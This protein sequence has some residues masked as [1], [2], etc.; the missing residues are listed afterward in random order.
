MK[1]FHIYLV[2]NLIIASAVFTPAQQLKNQTSEIRKQETSSASQVTV[3]D[4]QYRIGSGDVLEVRVF[5]RPQLSR[6]AV[7]VDGAGLVTMP[8]IDEGIRAACKTESELAHEIATRYLKYQRNPHVSVFVKEFNSQP[9]AV[10]GAVNHPGRFQLQRRLRLLEL[11]AFAGGPSE[12]AGGRIDIIRTSGA[13]CRT[14]TA[15]P[16]R[17]DL[18]ATDLISVKLAE[19]LSGD[20]RANPY[21]Q[22]GDIISMPEAEQA[23]VV[24]NVLKPSAIN[25]KEPVTVSRAI[26]MAG[27]VMPDTKL[28]RIR[29]VRRSS[30]S[31]TNAEIF[32]DLRAIDKLEAEDVALQSGDIV[33]VQASGGK[34][35]LRTLFS[36]IAPAAASVPVRVVR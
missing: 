33:D 2:T 20:D 9:V 23:F 31:G 16:D 26:A 7:R 5:N 35:F 10:I 32:V 18:V 21:V 29:I 34:R 17:G 12:R 15:I 27:G 28:N 30:Q 1:V 25:L 24:G 4:E 6:E 19:T 11:M 8:L 36:A 13:T 3:P 22:P 14:S